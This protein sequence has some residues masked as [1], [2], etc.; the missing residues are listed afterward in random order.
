L[1]VVSGALVLVAL[2]F[3]IIGL[4]GDGLG[5]IWASIITSVVAGVFLLLGALQ[6]R[7]TPAATSE[8]GPASTDMMERVTAVSVRPREEAASAAAEPAAAEAA[9]ADVSVVPGRPR[10]HTASCRFLAGRPDVETISVD[11][12]RGEGYTACGV[13]KPDQAVAAAAEA[14]AAATVAAPVM[15]DVVDEDVS[16]DADMDEGDEAA[17]EDTTVIPAPAARAA[18]KAPAKPAKKA[19][20]ATRTTA[21][22]AT[23]A[24]AAK[25]AP[26][27]AAPAKAA[28]AKAAPAKATKAAPAKAVKAAAKSTAGSTVVAV[29]DRGKYHTASCRFASAPGALEM[30]KT[31][32]TRQGLAACGVCKP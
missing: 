8:T 18:R 12:A 23:K 24:T 10:Y 19:A 28:P 7:G 15:D 22:R 14:P 16:D 9:S 11:D 4:F 25:A 29:P 5:F 20:A 27:K 13:C 1:I 2:V 6:R 3:L 30:S 31:A 21:A 26:A 32:A 17:S